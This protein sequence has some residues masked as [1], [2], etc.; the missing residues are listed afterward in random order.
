[1]G[2]TTLAGWKPVG[3]IALKAS[4]CYCGPTMVEDSLHT[5]PE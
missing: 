4:F 2:A 5:S 1:M 3:E